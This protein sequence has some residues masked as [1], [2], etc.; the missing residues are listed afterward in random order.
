MKTYTQKSAVVIV[1]QTASGK[2]DLAVRL[3]K[4]LNGEVISA[5]SR[6]VYKDFSLVSGKITPGE[7]QEVEHYLLD[8]CSVKDRVYSAFDFYSDASKALKKIE[9]K[10]KLPIVVGGTGFYIDVLFA[11][12]ALEDADLNADLRKMLEQKTKEEL[13][14]ILKDLS[15]EKANQIDK[16]NKRRLVRA[17]EILSAHNSVKNGKSST[18]NNEFQNWNVVWLGIS[19]GREALIERIKVRLKERYKQGM[20]GEVKTLMDLGVSESLLDS[21]GLEVRYCLRFLTGRLS[22]S[23]FLIELENKIWQYAKRQAT[24]WRRNKNIKWFHPDDYES[25]LSYVKSHLKAT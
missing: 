9:S 8:I 16:D 23:E 11:R 5:D 10:G 13:F 25:I 21:L 22:E 15:S 4:D 20:C 3:A 6:Q 18:I 1:G 14:E 17:I 24:Y 7:M 2:S 12:V 19:W